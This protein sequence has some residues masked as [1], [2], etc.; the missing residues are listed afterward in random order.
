MDDL[1]KNHNDFQEKILKGLSKY[2]LYEKLNE[3]CNNCEYCTYCE[4]VKTVLNRY[5]ESLYKLC[6]T[7]ARNLVNL[8]EILKHETVESDRCKY[9]TF[10]IHNELR[11]KFNIYN[12][13]TSNIPLILLKFF[14]VENKI[15]TAQKNN[16]CFYYYKSNI[17]LD[18][19]I[20]WKNLYDYIKNYVDIERKVTTINKLCS[21]YK[22]YLRYIEKVYHKFKSECC[23][24]SSDKCPD[25]IMFNEWCARDYILNK[26]SCDESIA[27]ATTFTGHSISPDTREQP[28]G[29]GSHSADSSLLVPRNDINEDGITN[30]TDYYSKLGVSLSF[31]GVLST[32]FYLYNFTTF[33]NWMRSKVLQQKINFNLDQDEQNLMEH[34]LNKD[35]ENMYA[36]G[37]NIKYQSS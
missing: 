34:N 25:S 24:N 31:L 2:E 33:G 1:G 7:F 4:F 37:Y 26:V 15:K 19:W 11:K 22:E 5:N 17:G 13:S 23:K 21:I 9:F 8:S 36:D 28:P 27:L 12:E 6:C 29:D 32:F 14:Q 30:N 20:Q 10:W 35:N 3:P 18:L 16:N